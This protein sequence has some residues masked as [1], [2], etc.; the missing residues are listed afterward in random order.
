MNRWS[1]KLWPTLAAVVVFA[2]TMMLG[3]WQLD[4]AHTKEAAAERYN[5][6]STLAPIVIQDTLIDAAAVD[7]RRVRA[8]GSWLPQYGIFLDNQV[9]NG[10]VGYRIYM[11]MRLAAEG[12]CVLVDRG[13]VAAG[14]DRA[15]LPAIVTPAGTVYVEGIASLPVPHFKELSSVYREGQIWENVT[16]ERFRLWSSLELQPVIIRQTGG[17]DDGLVRHWTKL[18]SGAD[19]NRGYAVQWFALAALT[20]LLWA[21]YFFRRSNDGE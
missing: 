21:Y 15:H 1:S 8:R 5:R 14:A 19:R 2:T 6:L 3:Q 11:P 18:D 13:W 7:L 4:R 9:D 20:L 10:R 12:L 17:N 16:L